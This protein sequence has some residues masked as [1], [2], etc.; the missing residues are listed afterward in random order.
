MKYLSWALYPL[1]IGYAIY[2]VLYESHKGWY[3]WLVSTA[4]GFI[5]TFGFIAMT[6]Q[7]FI[8]SVLVSL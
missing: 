7:L 3:S 4:A 6:P 2:S 5:Y 1:L 8:K